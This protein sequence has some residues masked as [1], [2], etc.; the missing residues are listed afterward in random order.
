M[1]ETGD[2]VLPSVSPNPKETAMTLK[3]AFIALVLASAP[4]LAFASCY[5]THQTSAS[6][7]AEGQVFDPASQSCVS[8]QTS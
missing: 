7:C 2:S 1:L 3:T 5:D 6:A 4:A 8:P